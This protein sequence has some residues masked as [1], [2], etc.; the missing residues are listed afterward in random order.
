[1]L[2]VLH[3]HRDRFFA[4]ARAARNLFDDVIGHQAERLMAA[5]PAPTREQ[6]MAITAAD[7]RAAAADAHPPV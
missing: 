5:G 2:T 6:L 7:V 4:N 1:V 3:A